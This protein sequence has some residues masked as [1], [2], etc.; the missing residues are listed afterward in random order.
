MQMVTVAIFMGEVPIQLEKALL[1][2]ATVAIPGCC[3]PPWKGGV[4]I[5]SGGV[6]MRIAASPPGIVVLPAGMGMSPRK[7]RASSK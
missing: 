5:P 2:L 6:P 1:R 3:S 4:P 7:F